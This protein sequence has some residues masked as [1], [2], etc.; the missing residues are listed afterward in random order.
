VI[1]LRIKLKEGEG[2]KNM[3]TNLKIKVKIYG[4]KCTECNDGQKQ[5]HIALEETDGAYYYCENC[6]AETNCQMYSLPNS[7]LLKEIEVELESEWFN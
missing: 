5:L 3:N 2:E 4:S 6:D 1:T 7:K